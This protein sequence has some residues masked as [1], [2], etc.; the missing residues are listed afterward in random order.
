MV[1]RSSEKVAVSATAAGASV[2][3]A[4]AATLHDRARAS[5]WQLSVAAF[6][7]ALE[8]SVRQA[9]AGRAPSSREVEQYLSSLHLSD[10][11]LACACAAGHESAWEH[12]IREHR[13]GLYR[14]ADAID[15]T[16]GGREL[17]DSLYGDLFGLRERNDQRQSLFR[18]F[19]G[20]SSIGSWVRAVLAQR[21]VDRLRAQRRLE[22]FPEDDAPDAMAASAGVPDDGRRAY[23]VALHAALAAAIAA[24]A[25]RD[26]LRLSCYYGQNMK[27]AATGRMLHEHEATVSRHL[28]KTRR[29]IRNDVEHRLRSIHG[30]DDA[31][32]A[33][34]FAAAADDSGS[35]DLGSMMATASA[36]KK[37]APDR[38]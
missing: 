26:R 25:P 1:H 17:A 32:I 18:Y 5:A 36:G 35:L 8:A 2:D 4:L 21:H 11:A 33:E 31:T 34:C 37:S 3:A 19:H 27:L 30:Y 6:A 23:H 12:F 9:F 22:P 13:P 20:R 28:T 16:G 24:L 38:S 10:L 29:D 7:A 15:R 14:A